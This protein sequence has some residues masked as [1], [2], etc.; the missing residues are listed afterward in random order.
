MACLQ[1]ASPTRCIFTRLFGFSEGPGNLIQT[2]GANCQ[3]LSARGAAVARSLQCMNTICSR[4]RQAGR[5][6]GWGTTAALTFVLKMPFTIV[7]Q[8]IFQSIPAN[9]SSPLSCPVLWLCPLCVKTHKT[10]GPI[11]SSAA[12]DGRGLEHSAP[13][14]TTN[15]SR[16]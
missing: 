2:L 7:I 16:P 10:P 6:S 1:Y 14:H 12:G 9:C 3:H 13:D 4:A 5:G 8:Y 15:Y 11:H